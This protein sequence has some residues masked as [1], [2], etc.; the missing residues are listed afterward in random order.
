MD[1][2]EHKNKYGVILADPPWSWFTYSEKG[3]AKSPD[4][5]Y[6][7]MSFKEIAS[8]PVESIAA[9]NCVLFLWVTLPKLL[10][11]LDVLYAWGFEY[12]TVA[13][14]WVKENKV[15]PGLFMGMGYWTRTNAEICLL[16]TKGS[17]RRLS[18]GVRQ[19]IVSPRREHSRKPD[20]QYERIRALV[21][22][23]YVEL[24]ARFIRPGWDC[25][26]NEV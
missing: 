12:K 21:P 26:G 23:P 14:V 6:P 3:R 17:P 2:W 9:D 4:R 8:L 15:S 18:G 22:G 16:G 7:L 20:E 11:G 19:V 1:I 13:F 10:E 25:W 5:H 24:F